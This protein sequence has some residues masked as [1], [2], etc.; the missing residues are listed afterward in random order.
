MSSQVNENSQKCSEAIKRSNYN[1]QYAR[2]NKVKILDVKEDQQETIQQLTTK[3][4]NILKD[5]G[6]QIQTE[7]LLAI[8][9][10]PSKKENI[11][12]VILKLDSNNYKTLIMRKRNELKAA[13]H[14]LVD[15]V[16]ALNSALFNRLSL[17]PSIETTCFFNGSVL[18]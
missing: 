15:D 6:I 8:H 1:E 3:V 9:G 10:I 5:K 16:T 17:H 4:L 11:R 14:R 18:L 13:G 7:Q 12:P 2:K